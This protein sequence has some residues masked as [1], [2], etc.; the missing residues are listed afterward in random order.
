[1]Q[2]EDNEPANISYMCIQMKQKFLEE[3][4]LK[5]QKNTV[6]TLASKFKK[7]QK[8][9]HHILAR[10]EHQFKT[11]TFKNKMDILHPNDDVNNGG[12]LKSYK[13]LNSPKGLS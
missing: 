3:K 12:Y 9:N 7:F 10:R 6:R 8:D 1:M 13:L 4:R 11:I 2:K 5:T